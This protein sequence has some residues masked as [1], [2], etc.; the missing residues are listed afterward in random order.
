MAMRVQNN[1]IRPEDRS[2]RGTKTRMPKSK[3][4]HWIT[5]LKAVSRNECGR[6]RVASAN[7]AR[8]PMMPTDPS[9]GPLSKTLLRTHSRDRNN[10][11]LVTLVT[12]GN[13]LEHEGEGASPG[14]GWAAKIFS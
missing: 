10:R 11:M 7:T 6:V 4:R 8:Q 2:A 1:R 14:P 3:R 5:S 13:L 12:I 9:L